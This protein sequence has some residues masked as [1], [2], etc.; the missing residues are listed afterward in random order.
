MTR[1]TLGIDDLLILN[2][3]LIAMVRARMPIAAGLRELG[4]DLEGPLAAV[5]GR[6]S[7]HLEQGE[8]LAT[9]LDREAPQIPA[10]Y[11]AIVAA[12]IRSGRLAV[13]IEALSEYLQRIDEIRRRTGLMLIYPS[14]VLGFAYL[15]FLLFLCGL[16]PDFSQTF[17]VFRLEPG[18]VMQCLESLRLSVMN[19]VWIPPLVYTV[20]LWMWCQSRIPTGR[21]TGS[22]PFALR[23]VPGVGRVL[24][25]GR[26]SAFSNLLSSLIEQQVPLDEAIQTASL[27]WGADSGEASSRLTGISM[28]GDSGSIAISES[29]WPAYLR[30]ILEHC[31]GEELAAQLRTAAAVYSRKADDQW[32]W[33]KC[34][35]PILTGAGLGG[36]VST[37]YALLVFSPVLRLLRLLS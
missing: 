32:R 5:A 33:I 11:S 21:T 25:S 3:E 22:L 1:P 9:A 15:G 17:R 20:L 8:D 7:K 34:I 18:I 19:W 31:S 6:L 27:G 36:L 16:L 13:A 30:W 12:G 35:F 28:R 23:I 14:V 2:Q 10:I 29:G 26:L 4:A 24:E 37:G